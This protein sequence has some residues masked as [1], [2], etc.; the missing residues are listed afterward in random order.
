MGLQ[1]GGISFSV[2]NV[3]AFGASSWSSSVSCAFCHLGASG[4]LSA[5][6]IDC[7]AGF[8]SLTSTGIGCTRYVLNSEAIMMVVSRSGW[9]GW[10]YAMRAVLIFPSSLCI[11]VMMEFDTLYKT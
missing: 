11:T 1:L 8:D 9:C 10:K 2:S 6:V 3:I 7:G 5:A 4:Y